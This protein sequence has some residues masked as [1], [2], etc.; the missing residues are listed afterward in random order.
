MKGVKKERQE[1]ERTHKE[2]QG[3]T[4]GHTNLIQINT[5]KYQDTQGNTRTDE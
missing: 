2:I 3:S 1:N 5:R 4:Q